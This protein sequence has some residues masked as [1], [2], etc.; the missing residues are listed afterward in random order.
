MTDMTPIIRAVQDA[1]KLCRTLQASGAE[2]SSKSDDSPVTI[3]DYGTQALICRA[4]AAHY[5]DEAV[6]AEEGGAA[7]QQLVSADGQ[8]RL[9]KLLGDIIGQAVTPAQVVAWLDHGRGVQSARTWV[10]DP[11]DGT[12]GFIGNRYYAICVGTLEQDHRPTAAAIGLPRSPI[13]TNGTIV[14]TEGSGAFA[15]S[16]DGENTRSVQASRRGLMDSLLVLESYKLDADEQEN[17]ARVRWAAQVGSATTELY[18]S[19]LK[20][21]MIATGYGDFFVRMPRDTVADPHKIW[22]HAPGAALLRAAGGAFTGT[23]GEPV[24]FSQGTTLPHVGF[25]ASNGNPVLHEALVGAVAQ[26]FKR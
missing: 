4:I 9:V 22:D 2:S 1:A 5:P 10:I 16:M 6:I 13:D 23:R 12:V 7:F 14:Y 21:S 25:I 8:A 11:I 18:D 15:M 17:A 24:D 20:Y 19:Q 3:A 26:V